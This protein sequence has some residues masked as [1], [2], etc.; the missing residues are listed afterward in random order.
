MSTG[1]SHIVTHVSVSVWDMRL[2]LCMSLRHESH[3]SCD[4]GL[5][6]LLRT[7]TTA[8]H[9]HT[10]EIPLSRTHAVRRGKTTLIGRTRLTSQDSS[11]RFENICMHFFFFRMSIRTNDIRESI[12]RYIQRHSYG[13][14]MSFVRKEWYLRAMRV[15]FAKH[16]LRV[17]CAIPCTNEIRGVRT[18]QIWIYVRTCSNDT[19]YNTFMCFFECQLAI[20]LTNVSNMN[21][22]CR[23][24]EAS[25]TYDY[26]A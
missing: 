24:C 26:V 1:M 16:A 8:K 4:M 15:T 10:S 25:L 23:T 2:I 5:M 22:W 13:I 3:E 6:R 17:I 19:H 20:Y 18:F 14:F 12:W 11:T 9:Q 21:V 7:S